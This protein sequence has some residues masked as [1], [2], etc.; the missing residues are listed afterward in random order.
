MEKKTYCVIHSTTVHIERNILEG[1]ANS[2]AKIFEDTT[3][4]QNYYNNYLTKPIIHK[5]QWKT[6]YNEPVMIELTNEEIDYWKKK[7]KFLKIYTKGG[8]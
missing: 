8:K 4:C 6:T 5:N 2:I 1:D 7:N 3:W